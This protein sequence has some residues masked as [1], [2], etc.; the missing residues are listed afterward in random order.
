MRK[1]NQISQ[2]Q[3]EQFKNINTREEKIKH[4]KKLVGALEDNF[5]IGDT[6]VKINNTKTGEIYYNHWKGG[7]NFY[8]VVNPMDEELAFCYALYE[9]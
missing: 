9:I 8:L 6:T 5:D 1:I 3:L 2:K 7:N 4:F